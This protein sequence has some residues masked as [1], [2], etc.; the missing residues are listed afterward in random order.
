MHEQRN[1]VAYSIDRMM[2]FRG[3]AEESER[4]VKSPNFLYASI[5]QKEETMKRRE[6]KRFV[7]RLLESSVSV[8]DVN[9]KIRLTS[10]FSRQMRAAVVL[11]QR[12]GSLLALG[13]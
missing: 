1:K 8:K 10:M 9:C 7:R 12:N 2:S 6:Q 5:P 4:S 11:R 13:V 3:E